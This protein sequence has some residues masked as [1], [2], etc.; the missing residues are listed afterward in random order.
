MATASFQDVLTEVATA[1]ACLIGQVAFVAAGCVMYSQAAPNDTSA[2]LLSLTLIGAGLSPWL[3]VCD[4][5]IHRPTEFVHFANHAIGRFLEILPGMLAG[6][7]FISVAVG[8]VIA[9][10]MHAPEIT[11]RTV[12]AIVLGGVGMS[13]YS[14]LRSRL[15]SRVPSRREESDPRPGGVIYY[16]T[17]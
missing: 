12:A 11:G 3:Y 5:G 17:C 9:A 2:L 4:Q 13:A 16:T 7:A 10:I 1:F 8:T 15:S 6:L 14:A